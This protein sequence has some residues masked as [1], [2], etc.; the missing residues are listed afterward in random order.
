MTRRASASSAR[1]STRAGAAAASVSRRWLS[2][3]AAT[4]V[5][6]DATAAGN[7]HDR[8]EVR[9]PRPKRGGPAMSAM[10]RIETIGVIG[11][12][13]AGQALARTARR[14]GRQV[15][16]A[17]SHGPESLAP[18]VAALGDGVSAGTVADAA[19]RAM[20]AL[21]VPWANVPAA[22]AGLA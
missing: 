6:P 7:V 19:R 2:I 14:A 5:F 16:I 1:G 12:G 15:V 17:N 4:V 21:A 10:D 8:E 20:V 22:V 18:V 3:H 9:R 13:H 11:A